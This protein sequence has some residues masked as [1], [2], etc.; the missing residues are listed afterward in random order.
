MTDENGVRW[1]FNDIETMKRGA[2]LAGNTVLVATQS[3]IAELRR[4]LVRQW[5]DCHGEV[6]TPEWPHKGECYREIP[7]VLAKL[8][9]SVIDQLIREDKNR[10]D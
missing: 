6:C 10:R 5:L 4:E 9:Q 1:E 8:S 3:E 7:A 2:S